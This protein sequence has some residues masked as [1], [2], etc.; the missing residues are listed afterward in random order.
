VTIHGVG[1]TMY[2]WDRE[3]QQRGL[4]FD[5]HLPE[6]FTEMAS[7]GLDGVESRLKYANTPERA[8]QFARLCQQAGVRIASLYGSCKLYDKAAVQNEV[9]QFL[10]AAAS[11]RKAGCSL[12]TLDMGTPHG[13]S[14]TEAELE[15]Q[16]EGLEAIGAGLKALNMRAALHNHTPEMRENAR[17]FRYVMGHVRSEAIGACLDLAWALVAGV[18]PLELI[19]EVHPRLF[20]MHV[21]N[22]ADGWFTE[23][24]PEGAISYAQIVNLLDQYGYDG[25]LIVELAYDDR[26]QTTRS[27]RQNTLRSVWYL[28]GILSHTGSGG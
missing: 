26:V 16:V 20:D 6:A 23:T 27:L 13:R 1:T 11:A 3:Y 28:K 9:E 22:V 19:R 2:Q 4:S 15:V 25:W 18:S 5:D 21:R 24:V 8:G 7:L 14:K 17:E 10:A 12:I